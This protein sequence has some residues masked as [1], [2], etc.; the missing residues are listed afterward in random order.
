MITLLAFEFDA[1]IY[2]TRKRKK[3]IPQSTLN[4]DGS[5][6]Q[7]IMLHNTHS[8][9]RTHFIT[10]CHITLLAPS[11]YARAPFEYDEIVATRARA[12]RVC[13]CMNARAR[14]LNHRHHI[15]RRTMRETCQTLQQQQRRRNNGILLRERKRKR[16]RA[17]PACLSVCLSIRAC[18]GDEYTIV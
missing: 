3:K 11:A 8:C 12:R 7:L 2:A 14:A 16:K 17:R 15:P 10:F 6:W 13:V 9:M 18:S 4:L 5:C 1:Q